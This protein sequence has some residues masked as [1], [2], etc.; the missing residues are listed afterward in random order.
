V[1][2]DPFVR[3][4]NNTDGSSEVKRA[5]IRYAPGPGPRSG[6]FP[7]ATGNFE[8]HGVEI[9]NENGSRRT[10]LFS[11]ADKAKPRHCHVPCAPAITNA[12]GPLCRRPASH[13]TGRNANLP[14]LRASSNSSVV[15]AKCPLGLAVKPARPSRTRKAVST[16]KKQAPVEAWLMAS[17]VSSTP[18]SA[19]QA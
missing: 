15:T 1:R 11:L 7:L 8:C 6:G 18:S 12:S 17:W 4:P 14:T 19:R 3:F 10:C 2:C 16:K 9:W 13:R 5:P